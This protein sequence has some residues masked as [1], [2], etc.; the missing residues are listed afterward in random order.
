M[1]MPRSNRELHG[2]CLTL[3]WLLIRRTIEYVVTSDGQR[4]LLRVPLTDTAP[5][6]AVVNWTAGLTK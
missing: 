3:I 5:I 2:R 4:F 1:Q 6:T